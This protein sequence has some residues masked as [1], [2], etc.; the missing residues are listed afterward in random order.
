VGWGN[1]RGGLGEDKHRRWVSK[2]EKKTL[3]KSWRE[4]LLKVRYGRGKERRLG[5]TT[6]C[7]GR[8]GAPKQKGEVM[9]KKRTRSRECFLEDRL[10]REVIIRGGGKHMGVRKK[11]GENRVREWI[12]GMGHPQIKEI[13]ESPQGKEK[14]AE[15][16]ET[17][18]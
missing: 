17:G 9:R 8:R 14:A 3:T 10:L 4:G 16:I 2:G 7:V 13:S 5:G 1:I 18:G 15:A 11:S 6:Y 12:R